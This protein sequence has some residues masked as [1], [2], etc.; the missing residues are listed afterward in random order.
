MA[1]SPCARLL[2]LNAVLGAAHL[3]ALLWL[4][5]APPREWDTLPESA[6]PSTQKP[7]EALLARQF[8]QRPTQFNSTKRTAL[9]AAPLDPT[10]NHFSCLN[11][12][13]CGAR[14]DRILVHVPP[15]PPRLKGVR[16]RPPSREY[17][18]VVRSL[19]ESGYYTD[20]PEEACLFLPPVDTLG[21]FSDDVG[22]SL[23]AL[24]TWNGGLNH[25]VLSMS[26]SSSSPR[27]GKAILASAGMTTSMYRSG[28]DVSL[29]SL[30]PRLISF[31]YNGIIPSA[32]SNNN[33]TSSSEAQ[34]R[35]WLVIVVPPANGDVQETLE[36][37]SKK[38]PGKVLLLRDCKRKT[39]LCTGGRSYPEVL[40]SGTFCLVLPGPDGTLA[41][42]GLS[43][44][45]HYGCVPV[46][47]AS[48]ALVPPFSE[49][50]DWS[51]FSVSVRAHELAS[52]VDILEAVPPEKAAEMRR[53]L[54]VV[55]GRHF[56]Y[57]FNYPQERWLFDL[58]TVSF[59][60]P[61]AVALT[62][63]RIVQERLL[64]YLN[65]PASVWNDLD[66]GDSSTLPF[67]GSRNPLF[68]PYSPP[69]AEGFTAVILTYDRPDTLFTLISRSV[70]AGKLSYKRTVFQKSY[71]F[72]RLSDVPS[73]SH[74]VVVWNNQ[75]RAPPPEPDW[76]RSPVP[77]TVVR[78][79]ANLLSNRFLPHGGV[80]RTECVLSLD[81]DIT[82]LTADELEM[83]FRAWREHPDRIVGFPSRTHVW[84]GDKE[85]WRCVI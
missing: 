21:A 77:R 2:L 3:V 53:R 30:S 8:M 44:A 73:L 6:G 66:S 59:R 32:N 58:R 39:G 11:V 23:G 7:V 9:P 42:P 47:G 16:H 40:S 68:L 26:P 56:R 45:M 72:A 79:T 15:L 13:R 70:K 34:R 46:L 64:P 22:S 67:P 5:R 50:L 62:A 18:D 37:L 31:S 74:V 82:M 71:F 76:P 60:S 65:R 52:A 14:H 51:R 38:Y 57:D 49:K 54:E 43:E 80:V 55:Y 27:I 69:E 12:T 35:E 84:E 75:D 10:C 28:F 48:D 25:M 19:A 78:A 4:W 20:R 81:D 36:Q 41:H 83:G 61:G 85:R 1:V 29:P 63:V 17:F 33:Y 24:D